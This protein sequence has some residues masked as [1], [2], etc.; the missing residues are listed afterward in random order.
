VLVTREVKTIWCEN[1]WCVGCSEGWQSANQSDDDEGEQQLS[2]Y[3]LSFHD[4]LL[5]GDASLSKSRR[6]WDSIVVDYPDVLK[7]HTLWQAKAMFQPPTD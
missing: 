3:V 6:A 1:H 2:K 5:P 7:R 4:F